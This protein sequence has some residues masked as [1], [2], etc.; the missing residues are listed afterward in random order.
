MGLILN[1]PQLKL[2]TSRANECVSVWGRGTGKTT[3]IAFIMHM[4][5][6][7]MPRST[8]LI[9]GSTYK[10]IEEFTFPSV[11][12]ALEMLGYYR[13][14]HYVAGQDPPKHWDLPIEPPLRGY[15]NYIIFPCGTAFQ[16]VSQSKNSTPPRGKSVDAII[17]DEY[18]MID[19]VAFDE[20]ISKTNR[21]NDDRYGHSYLHHGVFHHTSM[22]IGT[23]ASH[24]LDEGSHYL[25]EGFDHRHIC[26]TLAD[27]QLEL[28]DTIL[29][30][31]DSTE[32]FK[33]MQEIGRKRDFRT[34][35]GKYYS[36]ANSLDNIDVLTFDYIVR[37]R[38]RT[39]DIK[40]FQREILNKYVRRIDAGFYANLNRKL[41]TYSQDD[42]LEIDLSAF[43]RAD[44]SNDS[45]IISTLPLEIGL[46]WGSRINFAT[47]CQHVKGLN[48]FQFLKN[49]FVK[50]P[51]IIDDLADKIADYYSPHRTKVCYVWCDNYGNVS[52]A[53]SRL[54]YAQ[55]FRDRLVKR[56]WDV[57]LK[58]IGS[59]N[60][61]HAK[62]YLLWSRL[63]SEQDTKYPKVRF[64]RDRCRELLISMETAP[65]KE[66]RG[67]LQKDK[68]S[69][70]KN[71]DQEFATHGSDAADAVVWG[72]FG[73]LLSSDSGTTFKSSFR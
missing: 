38:R 9:V 66:N 5:T 26:D 7:A 30:G 45:D 71:I 59:V 8:T 20:E 22:P 44:C 23:E 15:R 29:A 47:I 56:G 21:G 46:D 49:I 37:E 52:Q 58:T 63:L 67:T 28:I 72:K 18:L 35:N 51:F 53:N 14:I 69:E 27:V 2:I 36:E 31:K 61:S 43:K 60:T 48:E 6:K 32:H 11:I 57:R 73:S 39:D 55:Q 62:R 25:L 13:N 4:I 70:K 17:T 1:N 50:E 42:L 3:M 12:K 19:K 64:N 34:I 41:H 33:E 65:T 24:I 10:Q 40:S 54:T 16:I 68:S